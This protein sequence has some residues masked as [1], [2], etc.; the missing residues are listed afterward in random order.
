MRIFCP[1]LTAVSTV[2]ALFFSSGCANA[3]T[4][5]NSNVPKWFLNDVKIAMNTHFPVMA[6]NYGLWLSDAPLNLS[7]E[8]VGSYTGS[9]K[10]RSYSYYWGTFNMADFYKNLTKNSQPYKSIIGPVKSIY[11]LE[12]Y[13]Q[14]G[15]AHWVH[16]ESVELG[17]GGFLAFANNQVITNSL[18]AG[19]DSYTVVPVKGIT[20]P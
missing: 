20:I 9:V 16:A 13:N 7:Q 17:N 3:A 1:V 18:H 19:V 2:A 14:Q 10:L 6:S 15:M 12:T 11:I 5:T 8:W 4:K